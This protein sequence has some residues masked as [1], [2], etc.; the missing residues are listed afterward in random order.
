MNTHA[1]LQ[2]VLNQEVVDTDIFSPVRAVQTT[3]E[4]AIRQW[5]NRFLIG[6]RPSGSFAKGTANWSGTDI[7]LFISLF[8]ETR[9]TLN[10]IYE[11]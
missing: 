1:F 7:D 5:A 9:E 2:P 11:S 4:P 3:L 10:E 8:S 6:V